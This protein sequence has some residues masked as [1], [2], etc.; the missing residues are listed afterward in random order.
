MNP[1]VIMAIVRKD[2]L[3]VIRNRHTLIA[4]LTPLFLAVLYW[5]MS[6]ALSIDTTT[7]VLYNP[8]NSALVSKE[9]LP[10]NTQWTIIP[11]PSADAVRAMVDNNTQNAAV[12]IVLPPDT[13]AVLR[14]G[15][16]PAV[17]VYFHG[18]KYSDF[19]QELLLAQ[20]VSAGQQISGQPPLLQLTPTVLRATPE[21]QAGDKGMSRLAAAFGMVTLLVGL[22]STGL[23]LV[24]SLLVEE[25]EKKTLRMILSAPASYADVV[26]G[27]LLVGL[28]YTLLL[29]A[30]LLAISRI[31]LDAMPQVIYFGLLGALLFL[32]C[33][34]LVGIVSKTG[35]EVNTYGTV[36]FLLALVSII[37]AM[38][39]LELAQG[40][41][42]TLLR[43]LPSF[44]VVDGMG[45]ALED[46]TT[47]ESFL[48]NSGVTL[49]VCLVLFLLATWLLRRQQLQT[50]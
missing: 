14:G 9:T 47:P 37:F 31:P 15:G 10:G 42:G 16:H 20:L 45:R 38:P 5:V 8:G 23:L 12:G 11:A 39:G 25:K 4:M 33:G 40:W 46:T 34:L 21:Q 3:D 35:G 27:K 26:L 28:I 13:D 24:P 36:I 41:L 18:A 43:L 30:V 2:M 1:A 32:L 44:Y 48:L 6:V 22:L 19:S 7:L 49:A 29:G 17:Q 50:G